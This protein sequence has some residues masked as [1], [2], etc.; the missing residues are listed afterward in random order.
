MKLTK[1]CT[2]ECLVCGA[3]SCSLEDKSDTFTRISQEELI[4]RLKNGTYI[5]ENRIN[6]KA[7]LKMQFDYDFKEEYEKY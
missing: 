3:K 2:G 7:W 4:N 1:G 5:G 6:A